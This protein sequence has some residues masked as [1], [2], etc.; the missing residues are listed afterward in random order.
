MCSSRLKL[1]KVEV[2]DINIAAAQHQLRPSASV[3][4]PFMHSEAA[5]QHLQSLVMAKGQYTPAQTAVHNCSTTALHSRLKLQ[6][7]MKSLQ[8][9]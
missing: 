6:H 9:D 1:R 4:L 5:I 2:E 8:L 7:I 3:C